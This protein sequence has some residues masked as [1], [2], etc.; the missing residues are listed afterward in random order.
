MRISDLG[1]VR[2]CRNVSLHMSANSH[3]PDLLDGRAQILLC[4]SLITRDSLRTVPNSRDEYH[5]HHGIQQIKPPE[6]DLNSQK[7]FLGGMS[8]GFGDIKAT[9]QNIPPAIKEAKPTEGLLE[10][11]ASNC[12]GRL[13]DCM[14]LL[15][16][17]ACLNDQCTIVCTQLCAAL[18]CFE[19]IKC[20]IELCDCDCF[21]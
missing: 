16:T 8:L 13:A 12:C 21:E 3:D 19:L 11:A 9:A 5:A 17:C 15:K 18:A 4:P 6:Y 2:L 1:I 20:C 7:L 14:C 10:K